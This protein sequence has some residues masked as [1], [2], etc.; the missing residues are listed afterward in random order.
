M[1]QPI[2]PLKGAFPFSLGTTSYIVPDDLVRNVEFL[3]P[4]VDDVEL[5]LFESSDVSNLPDTNVIADLQSL[6]DANEL[7]YTVHLPLD[8]R[9]GSPDE[10]VRMRSVDKCLDVVER[11]RPLAPFA[12]I[13]HFNRETQ[14]PKPAE[15]VALW[16]TALDRSVCALLKAGV[17]PGLLCVETLDYPFRFISDIISVHGL[18]ICLDIGHLAFYGFPVRDYLDRYLAQTRVVHAHGHCDGKDHKDIGLLPSRIPALLIDRL[19]SENERRHVLTLEVFVREDFQKSLEIV[20]R[21]AR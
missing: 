19:G 16:K 3:A 15:D 6:K 5:V 18:S 9:L 7:S 17:E 11:T 14:G 20:R 21:L 8:I 10:A 4:L 13:I 2:R 12:T 1:S